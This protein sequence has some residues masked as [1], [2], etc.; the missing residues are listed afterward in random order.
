MTRAAAVVATALALAA[1]AV[2]GAQA[3]PPPPFGISV[4]QNAVLGTFEPGLTADYTASTV[5]SVTSDAQ[6]ATLTIAD[7]STGGIPGH[8]RHASGASLP[9]ALEARGTSTD[10][11][12]TGSPFAPI[13]AAPLTLVSY[14]AP[15]LTPDPVTVTLRQH[16]DAT[17]PLRTGGYARTLLLTLSTTTP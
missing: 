4:T 16:V 13:G 15:V 12:A 10:P 11:A 9:S 3:P 1:P 5:V 8:L 14:G 6:A 7:V 17:D 2:A